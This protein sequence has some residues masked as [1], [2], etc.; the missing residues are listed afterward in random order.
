LGTTVSQTDRKRIVYSNSTISAY[1][2]GS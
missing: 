1:G 2:T